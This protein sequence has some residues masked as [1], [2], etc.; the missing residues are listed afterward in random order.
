VSVRGE[1]LFEDATPFGLPEPWLAHKGAELY[2]EK[3]VEQF[4]V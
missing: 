4:Y 1:E 2:L 3:P